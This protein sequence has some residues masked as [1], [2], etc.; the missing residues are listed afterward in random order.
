[1][2]REKYYYNNIIILATLLLSNMIPSPGV[3]KKSTQCHSDKNVFR[4]QLL[5]VRNY[6]DH[7]LLET[8][9]RLTS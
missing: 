3:I 7:I 2:F 4:V 9:I 8:L 6:Q 1:M 5:A